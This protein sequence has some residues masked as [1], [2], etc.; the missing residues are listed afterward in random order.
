[1]ARTE[2]GR[3]GGVENGRRGQKI[4]LIAAHHKG[5]DENSDDSP[6]VLLFAHSTRRTGD[7]LFKFSLYNQL[8]SPTALDLA[9]WFR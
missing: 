4:Y 2:E 5:A 7:L 8:A 6:S 1:M 3:R 9:C